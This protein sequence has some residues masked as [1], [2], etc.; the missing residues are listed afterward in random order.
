MNKQIIVWACDKL[1]LY[2]KDED[3]ARECW[4]DNCDDCCA[5]R[6]VNLQ[7]TEDAV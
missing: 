3:F 7:E 6:H 2:A 5:P 1:G 4:C